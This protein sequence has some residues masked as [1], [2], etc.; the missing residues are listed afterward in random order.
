MI[1]GGR[2][3]EGEEA[4]Y[5]C[6]T[7]EV[8]SPTGELWKLYSTSLRLLPPRREADEAFHTSSHLLL[9]EGL[10]CLVSRA[11]LVMK[12]YS[13]LSGLEKHSEEQKQM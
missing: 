4:G 1:D 5:H 12:G 7:L 6:R 8:V 9:A 3:M 10:T 11:C 2:E 13:V